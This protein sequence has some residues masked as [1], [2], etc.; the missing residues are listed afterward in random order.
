MG[1]SCAALPG[2][3]IV[4]GQPASPGDLTTLSTVQVYPAG[5]TGTLIGPRHV[6]TAAHCV[7]NLKNAPHIQAAVRFGINKENP[8]LSI[9][10][11]K[12]IPHPYYGR[13]AD[14]NAQLYDV[15]LILL[16]ADVPLPFKPVPVGVPSELSLGR[17]IVLA[18]YGRYSEN[19]TQS[20]PLTWV[21]TQI[22][23]LIDPWAEIQLTTG[24]KKAGCYGDSGG[25]TYVVHPKTSCLRVV[26]V[27]HG[28][29]RKG[30]GT[31]DTG[32]ETVM[33]LT[34][35][36]GWIDCSYTSL[37]KP[38]RGLENDGSEEACSSNA[39]LNF[40]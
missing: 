34:H 6:V 9:E 14:S 7:K 30:D 40:W 8:D 4:G 3:N 29:P 11:A 19:D 38:L 36:R 31:C 1:E 26:G 2:F 32:G 35:Y 33:N 16:A 15:A 27:T 12:L 10:I 20:R 39:V 25:P 21:K 18:G 5:C 23:E 28:P 37:G 22:E 24:T 17:D 13:S